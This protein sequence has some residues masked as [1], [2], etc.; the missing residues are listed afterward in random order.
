V[1]VGAA[2]DLI[3]ELIERAKKLKVSGGFEEGTDL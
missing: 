1:F 2:R 3:P